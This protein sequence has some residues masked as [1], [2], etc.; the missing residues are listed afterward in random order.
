MFIKKKGLFSFLESD[1]VDICCDVCNTT[2]EGAE[3]LKTYSHTYAVTRLGSSNMIC[4]SCF[5]K[6]IKSYR[7]KDFENYPSNSNC[8]ICTADFKNISI[9]ESNTKI[10]HIC[11]HCVKSQTHEDN[12]HRFGYSTDN[13][14]WNSC[15]DCGT[16]RLVTTEGYEY[17]RVGN[18]YKHNSASECIKHNRNQMLCR[19]NY[20]D[21][22]D[23]RKGNKK[24]SAEDVKKADRALK[25]SLPM[26]K[27][28][29]YPIVTMKSVTIAK[30][31]YVLQW[32]SVCGNVEKQI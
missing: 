14:V 26:L 21:V 13:D 22:A 32:C 8:C 2:I 31:G 28:D 3:A 17:W 4:V 5:N 15:S 7:W 12:Q 10:R 27:N 6:N 19:H 29:P 11:H 25:K 23:F 24:I 18:T 9:N 16:L 30:N 20:V 1:R